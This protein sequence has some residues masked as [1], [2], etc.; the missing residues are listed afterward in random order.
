MDGV[1]QLTMFHN[2]DVLVADSQGNLFVW[3]SN[4]G[5]IREIAPNNTVTTFAGGGSDNSGF[6]TNVSLP[7][8]NAMAM[9]TNNTIWFTAGSYSSTFY[10]YEI[11]IDAVVTRKIIS[12]PGYLSYSSNPAGIC[13]D[14]PANFYISDSYNHQIYRYAD[15]MI[16]VFAGSGNQGYADGN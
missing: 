13:V 6:G 8:I 16:S 7:S 12:T 11:T 15:G 1:G 4:N 10:L 14:S 3:D 2:P 9:N 5:R